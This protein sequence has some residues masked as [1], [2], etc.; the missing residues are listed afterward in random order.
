MAATT[1]W[2]HALQ[3]CPAP[4]GP[5]ST[6]LLPS[7]SN[8]GVARANASSVP[9]T[10]IESAASIAPFSPPLTG[11]SSIATSFAA[12]ASAITRVGPGSIELMSTTSDPGA[13]PSSTP[14]PPERTCSTSVVSGSIVI[15]MSLASATA[16]GPS[17]LAAPA[18]T[19]SSTGPSEREYTVSGKPA[20]SRFRAIGLPMMPRP[21]N[22]MRSPILR[23]PSRRR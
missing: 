16:A 23:P 7:A 14:P 20:A 5:T 9:P 1:N 17:A 19:S 10:M 8:T 2:L 11:A 15:V 12:N 18:S 21:M 4:L 3:T 22:P 6:M 13:A